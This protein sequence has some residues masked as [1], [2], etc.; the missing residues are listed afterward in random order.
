MQPSEPYS[1]K[2]QM[3]NFSE[4]KFKIVMINVRWALIAEIYNRQEQMGI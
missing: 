1:E 2:K 3:L 4:R